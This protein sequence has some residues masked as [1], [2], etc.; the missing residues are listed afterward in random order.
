MKNAGYGVKWTEFN[1]RDQLVTKRKFFATEEARERF[2]EKLS[3]KEN[4]NSFEA[5]VND[6]AE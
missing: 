6:I 4:F 1:K 3:E 2:S 5:W